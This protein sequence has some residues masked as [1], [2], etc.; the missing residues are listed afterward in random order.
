MAADA[1][2]IRCAAPWPGVAAQIVEGMVVLGPG[3]W[4]VDRLYAT[5]VAGVNPGDAEPVLRGLA[6]AGVCDRAAEDDHWTTP[7]SDS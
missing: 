4:S 7:L 3:P 2:V 6:A 5:A 1:D